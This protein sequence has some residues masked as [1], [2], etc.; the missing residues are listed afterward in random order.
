[1]DGLDRWWWWWCDRAHATPM[2]ERVPHSGARIEANYLPD[3]VGV[4]VCLCAIWCEGPLHGGRV[5][6]AC[7]GAHLSRSLSV[8]I[9][10]N[11]RVQRL[12][13][14]THS[15]AQH[16]HSKCARDALTLWCTSCYVAWLE[17]L[18]R[19]QYNVVWAI[20]TQCAC[21][22]LWCTLC[23][24]KHLLV[25]PC[26]RDNHTK[27]CA[28]VP[29]DLGHTHNITFHFDRN[30]IAALCVMVYGTGGAESAVR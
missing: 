11:L 5:P 17:K 18:E 23:I 30:L 24:T 3:S 8:C 4:C 6:L 19:R 27:K 29:F 10:R 26:A 22:H 1:M 28:V 25:V 13:T 20:L 14:Y 21:A 16:Q 15:I 9:I 2:G 7:F 12:I